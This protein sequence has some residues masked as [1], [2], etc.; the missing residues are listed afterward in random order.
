MAVTKQIFLPSNSSYNLGRDAALKS[1]NTF[2][3]SGH[4]RPHTKNIFQT[5]RSNTNK[6]HFLQLP[7]PSVRGFQNKYPSLPPPTT[8]E[9][10][11]C[12][13]LED[14]RN[15][16]PEGLLKSFSQ[17][18]TSTN[19]MSSI[20][21]L[22]LHCTNGSRACHCNCHQKPEGCKKEINKQGLLSPVLL[23]HPRVLC[24]S[25][26]GATIPHTVGQPTPHPLRDLH[27]QNSLSLV[28]HAIH[29]PAEKFMYM[30]EVVY[31]SQNQSHT[32]TV[33]FPLYSPVWNATQLSMR[34]IQKLA[35]AL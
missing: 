4:I 29:N 8:E 26:N 20:P 9:P 7:S 19:S 16:K 21:T 10:G 32:N 27:P 17:R 1:W 23:C 12:S 22:G 2:S 35:L 11:S 6:I 15:L 31:H 3:S 30:K 13:C 28:I 34:R 33:Y 25:Y 14:P 24:I 5:K 18:I